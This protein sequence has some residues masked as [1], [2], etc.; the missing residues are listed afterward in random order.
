MGNGVTDPEVDGNALPSFARGKSLISHA[1]YTRLVYACN[2]SYWD[3]EE[4][5]RTFPSHA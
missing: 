3:A 1:H 5:G 2:S 4:G